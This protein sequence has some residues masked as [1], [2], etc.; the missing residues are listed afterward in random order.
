MSRVREQVKRDIAFREKENKPK[1][2]VAAKTSGECCNATVTIVKEDATLGN[3]LRHEAA[4]HPET[5]FAGYSVLH[6]SKHEIS[7]TVQAET[8]KKIEKIL[9]DSLRALEGKGAEIA[10]LFV[11]RLAGK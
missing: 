3:A 4:A 2:T 7:L 5:H 10:D 9:G 6:P 1:I 8:E 11:S